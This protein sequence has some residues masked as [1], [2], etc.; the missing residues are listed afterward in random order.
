MKIVFIHNYHNNSTPSG[1]NIIYDFEKAQFINLGNEVYE[2][3]THSASYQEM[4]FSKI[5]ITALRN[6]WNISFFFKS[7]LFFF[8]VKPDI[9]HAHNVFPNLSF[10]FL[11]AAKLLRIPVVVTLHNY[12]L[13]CGAGIPLRNS[14]P[15]T[16]C[17]SQKSN[18]HLLKYKCYKGSFLGSLSIYI[19]MVFNKYIFPIHKMVSTFIALTDFQK[20]LI[21]AGGVPANKI[22]VKPNCFYSDIVPSKYADR[23]SQAVFVGRLS[24]EKGI[25]EIL[26]IWKLWGHDA[27]ILRII[28]SGPLENFTREFIY[29]NE[30]SNKVFLLGNRSSNEALIEIN[31]SKILVFPSINF[32]GFPLVIREAFYFG[33]PVFASSL[34]SIQEI[35]NHNDTGILFDPFDLEKALELLIHTWNNKELLS[36]VSKNSKY[37]FN[38][39]YSLNAHN[40]KINEIYLDLI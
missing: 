21:S 38:N 9:I 31:K 15:C 20:N 23:T 13:V 5:L 40:K 28:G 1:E 3:V 16:L 26:T 25:K 35:I 33:T 7:L 27:P 34:G 11:L 12:R 2:L 32:E 30:M 8:K 36:R 14:Q 24:I 18:F 29:K 4:N 39:S 22:V 10:S 19:S 17:I 6:I 37:V